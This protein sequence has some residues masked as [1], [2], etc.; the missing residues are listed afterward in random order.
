MDEVLIDT[1]ILVYAYDAAEPAKHVRA[2]E[3]VDT[4]SVSRRGRLSAQILA[5]FVNSTT[6]G[7]RPILSFAEARTYVGWFVDAFPVFDVTRHVILEALRGV[8]QHRL[9]YFDAQIW[10]TAKLNQTSTIFT[11]DFQDGRVVEGVRFI[12]PLRPDFDLSLWR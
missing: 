4:L 12:N 3:I 11:E 2:I 7:K 10:A 5:E 8:S 9:S 6:S 1:N